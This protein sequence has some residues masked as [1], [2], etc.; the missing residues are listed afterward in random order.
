M[1]NLEY[2]YCVIK[3]GKIPMVAYPIQLAYTAACE[4]LTHP[5]FLVCRG[6]E[7]EVTLLGCLT[8]LPQT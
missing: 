5:L 1:M 7:R 3:H 2:E 4:C 6:V 8:I